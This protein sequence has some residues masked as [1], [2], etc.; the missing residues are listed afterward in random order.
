MNLTLL[1]T[2]IREALIDEA[3][4]KKSKKKKNKINKKK[5]KKRPGRKE[6]YQNINRKGQK[7]MAREINK[8]SSA[9]KPKGWKMP[10]SCYDKEWEADKEKYRTKSK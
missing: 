4:K 10:K 9:G 7:E 5:K 1:E 2:F 6:Y 8:C 3:K